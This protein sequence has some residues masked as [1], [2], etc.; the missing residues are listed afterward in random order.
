M[1]VFL[2]SIFILS[3]TVWAHAD[4]AEVHQTDFSSTWAHEDGFATASE[5]R[6][7]AQQFLRD[8]MA[9]DSSGQ[10][11]PGGDAVVETRDPR[12]P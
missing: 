5:K 4:E 2:A 8:L 1:R 3:A 11:Q 6:S 9:K 7:K 10:N 12:A